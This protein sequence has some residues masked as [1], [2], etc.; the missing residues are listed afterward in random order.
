MR[1]S[2]RFQEEM[3]SA[4]SP[5]LPEETRPP[6]HSSSD[7]FSDSC[8]LAWGPSLVSPQAPSHTQTQTDPHCGSAT[9]PLSPKIPSS[10]LLASSI[11][12]YKAKCPWGGL[13]MQREELV[14]GGQGVRAFPIT[15]RQLL[16]SNRQLQPPGTHPIFAFQAK[17]NNPPN[18]A[19][20]MPT[21]SVLKPRL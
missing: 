3:C 4:A 9:S 19:L 20:E 7:H 13:V 15:R 12:S 18:C 16:P 5:I 2:G 6:C 10:Y 11:K 14:R 17:L 8:P 21:T 1:C